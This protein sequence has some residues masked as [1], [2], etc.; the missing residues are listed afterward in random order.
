[1]ASAA[2]REITSSRMSS[3]SISAASVSSMNSAS[4]RA[5]RIGHL[6]KVTGT[7]DQ[8]EAGA[9]DVLGQV[10]GVLRWGHLVFGA[11]D[12]QGG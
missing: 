10:L 7:F 2:I 5:T 11:A 12:D 9:G 8:L 1:V 3:A 4:A 6:W